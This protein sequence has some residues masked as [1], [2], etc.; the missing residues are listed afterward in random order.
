[1]PSAGELTLDISKY[2][3]AWSQAIADIARLEPA[4]KKA[5]A[6]LKAMEQAFR[7]TGQASG[8]SAAQIKL[9]KEVV[10]A[11]TL[12]LRSAKT[13]LRAFDAQ[14]GKTTVT[15]K[16][17]NAISRGLKATFSAFGIGLGVGGIIAYGKSLLEFGKNIKETSVLASVLPEKLQRI[18]AA[19]ADKLSAD[20]SASVLVTLNNV[21]KEAARGSVEAQEKLEELG[22]TM[23]DIKTK[24]P[25]QAIL[26]LADHVKAATDPVDELRRVTALF[27]EEIGTRLI[28][29]LKEGGDAIKTV[30]DSATVASDAM[31]NAADKGARALDS[32]L[33]G[34]KRL[35]LEGVS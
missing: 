29:K 21:M 31:I 14:L 27:G 24:S 2:E 12:E 20:E 7:K 8:Y 22:V 5:N 3:A 13:E 33:I 15:S 16:V 11:Q 4:V 19:F 30:G 9:Q 6:D 32:W 28:E 34:A 26:M 17:A 23:A 35:S 1:M 25:D 18:Q 10:K